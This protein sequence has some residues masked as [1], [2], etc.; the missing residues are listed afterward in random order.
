MSLS[1]LESYEKPC[2][3]LLDEAHDNAQNGSRWLYDLTDCRE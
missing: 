1:A 2:V 3:N